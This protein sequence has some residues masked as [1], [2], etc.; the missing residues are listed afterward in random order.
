MT[1]LRIDD[2]FPEHKKVMALKGA[3]AKWLHLVALCQSARNLTDG[4]VDPQRLK[5][6]CAIADVPRAAN[7]VKQLVDAG[8]WVEEGDGYIIKDYLDYNPD[9]ETVKA[10]REQ[11]KEAGKKAAQARWGGNEPHDESDNESHN[12]TYRSSGM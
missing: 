10:K 4:H 9:A 5:V 3:G 6:V 8:L 1:W 12:E 11:R 7:C 2:E